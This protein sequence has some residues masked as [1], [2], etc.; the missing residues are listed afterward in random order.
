MRWAG[1]SSSASRRSSESARWAPRLV[2]ATACTSSRITVS[3][4]R[5]ASRACEVSI[6]N[7]DSGVVIRM[8]GG[9]GLQPAAVGGRG[10][11]GPDADADLR[12]LRA[13]PLGGVPDPGERG[14]QVA[15]DV[16]RERLERGDVEHPA[17]PVRSA[18]R[19][20]VASRSIAQRN[21]AS[22]LPEP[23]GATTR[24]C[25]PAAIASH[26]ST[27]AAVGAAKAASNQVRV[28]VENRPGNASPG[29]LPTAPRRHPP[30][31]H[32]RCGR[33][34]AW[35]PGC[36]HGMGERSISVV[37]GGDRG[38][39]LGRRGGGHR[40][41]PPGYARHGHPPRAARVVPLRRRRL[42]P[43]AAARETT[44]EGSGFISGAYALMS[45]LV[46][47]RVWLKR[48]AGEPGRLRRPGVALHLGSVAAV[49]PL[50]VTQ[51]L[52]AM[53]MASLEQRRW[54]RWRDWAAALS[55]CGGL[56]LLLVVV[57]AVPTGACG[58]PHA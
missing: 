46:R 22:V 33:D 28:A 50:L 27:C 29:V 37:P 44:P 49:Q 4:P 26:A 18:G 11:A 3:T 57:H 15:L 1:R 47:D 21:A 43:A 12:H 20:S 54:P 38:S 34:R 40:G 17:A 9:R 10:V 36:G 42:L 16:D 6:R 24:A 45:K 19:G 2:P 30:S 23:V 8:S 32:R 51:L 48:L 7:S 55:I 52:F 5:S 25:R 39:R 13:E 56:V 58:R 53:P 35:A 14:A 31:P 41:L